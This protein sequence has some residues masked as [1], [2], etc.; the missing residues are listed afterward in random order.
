MGELLESW[1]T[2]LEGRSGFEFSYNQRVLETLDQWPRI[3]WCYYCDD[4]DGNTIRLY[5]TEHFFSF[6]GVQYLENGKTDG[7]YE[8]VII[9][10]KHLWSKDEV[11]RLRA[12][13]LRDQFRNNPRW[14]SWFATSA[15]A[16]HPGGVF[17]PQ[18]K[19]IRTGSD[20]H[21]RLS[22]FEHP[23]R[24]NLP[25]FEEEVFPL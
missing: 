12:S 6:G 11:K 24:N 10:G 8:R 20:R 18:T 23:I 13:S 1:N 17:R 21:L 4:H 22:Y 3:K 5:D 25:P 19:D 9:R 15:P 7:H 14:E 16:H 2:L